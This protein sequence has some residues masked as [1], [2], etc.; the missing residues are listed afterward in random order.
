M[1]VNDD[2]LPASSLPEATADEVSSSPAVVLS[3]LGAVLP[4]E[5]WLWPATKYLVFDTETSAIP[6][7]KMPADHPDQPRLASVSFIL[8]NETFAIVARVDAMV[9]PDG[10]HMSPEASQKTR[11]TDEILENEGIPVR[12]VLNLYS[13]LI[14]AGYIAVAHHAQFDCKIM[15][16]ELRRAG[17]SDLFEATKQICTMRGMVESCRIPAK[18]GRGWKWPK[19]M[20]AYAHATGQELEGA[21]RSVNDAYACWEIAKFMH[22]AGA[23]PEAMVHYSKSRGE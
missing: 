18:N 10:W 16:G 7:F 3:A 20:E 17:M 11:L 4:R 12:E 6:D 13:E 1:N 21:H 5:V 14:N 2:T 23:L 9:K 8:C 19:L 22:S 15:R